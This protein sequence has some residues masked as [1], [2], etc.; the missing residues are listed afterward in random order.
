[1]RNECNILWEVSWNVCGFSCRLWRFFIDE[2]R[3][4]NNVGVA[5]VKVV[6]VYNLHS[7]TYCIFIS[8]F[9]LLHFWIIYQNAATHICFH[10]IFCWRWS[11]SLRLTPSLLLFLSYGCIHTC[12]WYRD[13]LFVVSVSVSF[14]SPS[15]Y[16]LWIHFDCT[17]FQ[18]NHLVSMSSTS[19]NVWWVCVTFWSFAFEEESPPPTEYRNCNV[20]FI[21]FFKLE[22]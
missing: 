5:D 12:L 3:D 13:D 18:R 17:S 6:G 11:L 4:L 10:I 7:S 16:V 14:F 22:L 2:T 8:T 20:V 1:M 19:M 21:L 9:S 15:P